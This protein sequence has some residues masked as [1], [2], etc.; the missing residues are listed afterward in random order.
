MQT[1]VKLSY[2]L[3]VREQGSRLESGAQGVKVGVWNEESAGK[4]QEARDQEV[5]T[6]KLRI[7]HQKP[8]VHHLFC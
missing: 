7:W 4:N 1:T 3:S 8:K 6:W 2:K 5:G